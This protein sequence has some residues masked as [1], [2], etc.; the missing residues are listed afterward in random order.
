VTREARHRSWPILS[1]S[2]VTV[3][4]CVS[5]LSSVAQDQYHY[6]DDFST[7]KADADSYDHSA[8][9]EPPCPGFGFSGW[10]CYGDDS[11]GDRSLGFYG[12]FLLEPDPHLSYMFPLD[13]EALQIT[14]GMI[15][16]E[17]PEFLNPDRQLRFYLSYD[18]TSWAVADTIM[19][20][21]IY[22]YPLSPPQSCGHVYIRFSGGSVLLDDL[23]VTL[24]YTTATDASAW[25]SIKALFR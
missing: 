11:L 16:F 8:M 12:G 19:T 6:F 2:I 17:I 5:S 15:G 13:V 23:T 3:L 18:G 7:N 1:A 20:P 25:G 10:L 9:Y 14:G 24:N 21:G 22:D 4:L